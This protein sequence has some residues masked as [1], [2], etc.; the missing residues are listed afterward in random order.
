MV[1]SH[2]IKA[3]VFWEWNSKIEPSAG[4]TYYGNFNFGSTTNNPLDTNYGYANA[5]LGI[6]QTYGEATNRAV[7]NVHFTELDWYIQDSWRVSKHLTVDYG[8]RFVHES[9]VVDTS[10]TY[11]DFYSQ[12]WNPAQA[13]VLYGQGSVGGKSAAVNPLTG[14]T[15]FASLIG[16]IIPGSG[17]PVDGMHIDGLTGKSDFYTF[18]YLALA[19]RLGFA[20][21]PN[22]N[23]K[24]VIRASE[25]AVHNRSTNNVPGSG[26]P[27]LH[28]A[29][30]T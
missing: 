23:G 19:P 9:P 8:L 20:W 10:G 1:G 5:L 22:G 14:Q 25:R 26:A 30:Y 18:P 21:D 6:Y 28:A 12:L 11:S 2:S 4:S 15:T 17:N 13:P 24:M 29:L 7:P 27:G 16:T 3:G